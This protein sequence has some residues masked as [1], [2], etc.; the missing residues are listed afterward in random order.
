MSK[1]KYDP[2]RNTYSIKYDNPNTPEYWKQGIGRI[3]A[4]P[5]VPV[6]EGVF[7]NTFDETFN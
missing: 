5:E 2:Y 7:D 1:A 6:N 3:R 4:I